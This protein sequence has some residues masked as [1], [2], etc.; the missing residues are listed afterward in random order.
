LQRWHRAPDK[1][2]LFMQGYSGAA[3]RKAFRM[4]TTLCNIA[5]KA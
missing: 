5:I 4:V 2:V 3:G 1:A